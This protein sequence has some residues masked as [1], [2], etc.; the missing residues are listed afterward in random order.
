MKKT[1]FQSSFSFRFP[2]SVHIYTHT[3]YSMKPISNKNIHICI[4]LNQRREE[5]KKKKKILSLFCCCYCVVA[6]VFYSSKFFFISFFI[7]FSLSLSMFIKIST[8]L[9]LLLRIENY[10]SFIITTHTHK[11]DLSNYY[12]YYF[13]YSTKK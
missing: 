2:S 3:Y 4:Y 8:I 1:H 9:L 13:L 12:Y 11:N 5:K 10:K 7:S 6:C